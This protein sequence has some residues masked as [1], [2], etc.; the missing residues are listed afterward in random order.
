M[1][2]VICQSNRQQR[3]EYTKKY[4][5]TYNQ[6]MSTTTINNNHKRIW[7]KSENE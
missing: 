4:Q 6:A 1:I 7:K 3:N 2:S 5:N